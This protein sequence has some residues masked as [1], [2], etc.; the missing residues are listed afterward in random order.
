MSVVIRRL[1]EIVLHEFVFLHCTMYIPDPFLSHAQSGGG[2]RREGPGIV[3]LYHL[4]AQLT[5]SE[6]VVMREF[7]SGEE[8]VEQWP[9][10][11]LL[12]ST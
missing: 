2:E 6:I 8:E 9:L 11:C 3:A 1:C 12:V 5:L 7:C 4:E 10:F